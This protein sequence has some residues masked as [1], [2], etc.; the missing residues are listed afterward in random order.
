MEF[1]SN[2]KYGEPVEN[3]SIFDG[4]IGNLCISIHRIFCSEGWYLTCYELNIKEK[5]LKSKELIMAINESKFFLRNVI[6]SLQKDVNDF[7][8]EKIEITR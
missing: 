1:K 5:L 8:K 4:K 7:C 2:A 6:D 3:G